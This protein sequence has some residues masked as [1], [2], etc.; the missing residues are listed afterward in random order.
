MLTT[1]PQYVYVCYTNRGYEGC[2]EPQAAF[3]SLHLAEIY[4]AGSE[5]AYSSGAKIIRLPL[6]GPAPSL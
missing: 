1:E 4:Q 6:I 5:S 3:T 2:S